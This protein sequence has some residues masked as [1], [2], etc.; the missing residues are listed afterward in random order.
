[1]RTSLNVIAWKAQ[2]LACMAGLVVNL[3]ALLLT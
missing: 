3:K 2:G 1:M